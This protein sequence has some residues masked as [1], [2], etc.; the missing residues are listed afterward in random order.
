M[1]VQKIFL[2]AIIPL[3]LSS[4]SVKSPIDYFEGKIYKLDVQQGNIVSPQM[5]AG[6][7]PR[8]TR[9]QVRFVLGTPLIQDAFHKDRW[10]YIFRLIKNEQLI[11]ER[12]IVVKFEDDELVSIKGD[13]INSDTVLVGATTE[14]KTKIIALSKEDYAEEKSNKKSLL[15]RMKFWEDD[16]KVDAKKKEEAT[17]AK[18][19]K[20]MIENKT[21]TTVSDGSN[22]KETYEMETEK[23]LI[24]DK[25][26]TETVEKN[27]ENLVKIDD[28]QSVSKSIEEDI[29]NSLPDESD[30]AYFDLL[31]EKIGF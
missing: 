4:C 9:S 17:D 10:D 22:E 2:I 18:I 31:L 21:N 14:K 1:M 3:L 19:K 15:N 11:E 26:D 30:P 25:I 16:E 5:I 7:K 23:S 28:E 29:L 13:L 8:M 24:D 6:L 27:T 12:H 20:E